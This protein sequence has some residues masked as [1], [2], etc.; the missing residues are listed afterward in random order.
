MLHSDQL[1]VQAAKSGNTDA[2]AEIYDRHYASIYA[3]IYYRVSDQLVAE[4]LSSDVFVRMVD[5]IRDFQTSD[6]P[7]LAWLFTIAHNLVVDYY[8]RNP[9]AR[10]L[11]IGERLPTNPEDAPELIAGQH[12]SRASLLAAMNELTEAQRQ[13][14]FLRFFEGRNHVEVAQ[15]LNKEVADIK[16]L[17]ARALAALRRILIK[18]EAHA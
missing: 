18:Q 4:D 1:L 7:I 6:R 14:V 10:N 2:L 15:I 12:L 11:P 8:R 5:R 13:V 9:S 16:S 3:Y 17:Q